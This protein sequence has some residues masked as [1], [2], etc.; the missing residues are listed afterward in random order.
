MVVRPLVIAPADVDARPVRRDIAQGMVQHLDVKCRALEKLRFAQFLKAG[1]AR[2]R[3]I[4]TI[5]L[6]DEA[7]IGDRFVFV[8]HRC[9]DGFDIGLVRGIMPVGLEYRHKTG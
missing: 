8:L 5:E 9:G 1:V 7:G 2:H 6:Q 3:E 4:G